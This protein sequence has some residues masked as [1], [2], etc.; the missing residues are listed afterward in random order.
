VCVCVS[1]DKT[2]T[3]ASTSHKPKM[4]YLQQ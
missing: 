4:L 3:D 2:S 1:K